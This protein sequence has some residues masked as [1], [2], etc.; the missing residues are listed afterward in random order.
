V[1]GAGKKVLVILDSL[2]T[3]DHVLDELRAYWEPE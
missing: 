3:K 1:R 2:R